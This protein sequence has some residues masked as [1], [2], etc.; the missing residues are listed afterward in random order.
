MPSSRAVEAAAA[1]VALP[2][3]RNDLALAQRLL[4]ISDDA[5][6]RADNAWRQRAEAL[7]AGLAHADAAARA[8]HADDV[9]GQLVWGA[10]GVGVG[11]VLGALIVMGASR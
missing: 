11:V 2:V 1:V 8:Q 9:R 7:Q 6:T 5:R 3:C 10:V 4:A